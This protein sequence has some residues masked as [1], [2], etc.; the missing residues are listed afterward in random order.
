MLSHGLD[1]T[2]V[3]GFFSFFWEREKA[4]EQ[5]PAACVAQPASAMSRSGSWISFSRSGIF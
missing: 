4:A 2:Q 3:V 1:D 5:C